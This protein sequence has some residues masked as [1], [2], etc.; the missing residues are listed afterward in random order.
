[1]EI[2]FWKAAIAFYSSYL[3]I[4]FFLGRHHFVLAAIFFFFWGPLEKKSLQNLGSQ[5][6]R[7]FNYERKNDKFK[8][9]L[10]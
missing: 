8:I 2:F 6:A 3:M 1:V 10:S 4:F 7:D 5:S 9:S